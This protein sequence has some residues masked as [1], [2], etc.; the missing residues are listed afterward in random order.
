MNNLRL[1]TRKRLVSLFGRLESR[2][3]EILQAAEASEKISREDADYQARL[4]KVSPPPSGPQTVGDLDLYDSI[5]IKRTVLEIEKVVHNAF[6]ADGEFPREYYVWIVLI[7]SLNALNTNWAKT[8]MV[9]FYRTLG[10]V[11][12]SAFHTLLPLLG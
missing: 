9:D 8:K 7:R 11:R 10:K 5:V 4:L 6:K 2:F 12:Y 3:D 1:E